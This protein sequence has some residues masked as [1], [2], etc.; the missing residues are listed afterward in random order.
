M[1]VF[2]KKTQ[3]DFQ[4]KVEANKNFCLKSGKRF[5]NREIAEK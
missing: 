3:T 5:S 1:C 4:A 2:L